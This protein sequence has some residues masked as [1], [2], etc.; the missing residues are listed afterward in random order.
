MINLEIGK[1]IREIESELTFDQWVGCVKYCEERFPGKWSQ[2]LDDIEKAIATKDA[3]L[4]AD[5]WRVFKD[6]QISMA[7]EYKRARQID[8]ATSFLMSLNAP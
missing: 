6:R 7:R 1:H 8:D 5:G 4:I 2:S 3:R